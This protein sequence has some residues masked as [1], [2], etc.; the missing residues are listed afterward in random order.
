MGSTFGGIEIGKRALQVQKKSLDVTGQNIANANTEGYSR[1]EVIQ[2]TTKPHTIYHGTGAGQVGTGVKIDEIRRIRNDFV[3]TQ[4]REETSA[5]GKWEMRRDALKEIELIFN[6]PS[7]NSLR[8]TMDEFWNSLQELNNN[9]ESQAVRATVRQRGLALTD[10]FNSLD[11]QLSD[12]RL[13]LNDRIRTKVEDINSYAQRIADLNGQISRIESMNQNP[14]DLKDKRDLLIDKLSKITSVQVKEDENGFANIS[15][16]GQSLVWQDTASK[17]VAEKDKSNSNLVEVKWASNNEE[18]KFTDGAIKGLLEARDTEIPKYI[19][20][21][22][23]M[24]KKMVTEFNNVHKSGYGLDNSTNIDFFDPTG[25]TA[26]S[27]DLSAAIKNDLNKIAAASKY[28]DTNGDGK[29]DYAGDGSNALKLADLGDQKLFNS[30]TATFNSY[31]SSNVAQLGV[32][33]QRAK[34][35]VNN[36]EV[37]TRQLNKQRDSISGVS[38]DEEMAKMIKYQHSYSAAAKF[39]STMDE[40][41][42]VLVNGIKR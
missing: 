31:Y 42:G 30:G 17:L 12:Y 2:S 16:E 34:R 4:I 10:T 5:K 14:N 1:Q 9:P 40:I 21:L 27:M 6:E 3:D 39:V 19:S 23:A 18:V 25:I 22:D 35:M 26:K 38:L 8:S 37:L 36:Q 41:L 13:A 20:Q 29:N 7:D 15:I 24:A 32:D 33:S 11:D 28:S